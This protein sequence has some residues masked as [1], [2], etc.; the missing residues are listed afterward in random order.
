[1]EEW[2]CKWEW[3]L[4]TASHGCLVEP[5]SRCALQYYATEDGGGWQGMHRC[6]LDTAIAL[7]C[8]DACGQH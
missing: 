1:M 8:W 4:L 6:D 2:R 3:D 7:T 5:K